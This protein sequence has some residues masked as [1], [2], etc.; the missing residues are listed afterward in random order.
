[1]RTDPL[2]PQDDNKR[3]EQQPEIELTVEQALQRL[4]ADVSAAVPKFSKR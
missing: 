4:D 2:S 3:D 1:M